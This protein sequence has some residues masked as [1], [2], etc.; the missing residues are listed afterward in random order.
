MGGVAG[1]RG[2]VPMAIGGTEDHV[3]LLLSLP[4]TIS[5]SSAMQVIKIGSS[6]WMHDECGVKAFAWQEGYGAF[7]IGA[8]QVEA[9]VAYIQRQQEHHRRRD[10]Q[11]E[12][13]AILKK[14][15]IA[16]DARYVWD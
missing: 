10:F 6:R 9:T 3:H 13:L 14:N 16:Y 4:A 1:D 7:S 5:V 12:F 11:A 15:G 8:S 2:V